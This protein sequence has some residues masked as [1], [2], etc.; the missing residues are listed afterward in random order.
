MYYHYQACGLDFFDCDKKDN[1]SF[2]NG[3]LS[4]L[5]ETACDDNLILKDDAGLGEVTKKNL[6]KF[7][8]V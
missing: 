3:M 2:C 5:I 4:Y 8:K 7:L 6:E 1:G